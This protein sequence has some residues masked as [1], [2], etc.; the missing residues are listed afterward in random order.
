VSGDWQQHGFVVSTREWPIVRVD[1][2]PE[3]TLESYRALFAHFAAL[4]A[5]GDRVA[6]LI[7]LTRFDPLGATATQ[8][9][10]AAQ[11][12]EEHRAPLVAGSVCEARVI[13]GRD[14]TRRA[15]GVR[16]ADAPQVALHER[17]DGGR[18][19]G[20]DRHEDDEDRKRPR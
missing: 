6:W 8:R 7:D 1:Y 20:L 17:R 19:A 4:A 2:P 15:H 14:H 13:E 18:G 3:F 12:F 10:L 9:R 5:R 16:L 11:V